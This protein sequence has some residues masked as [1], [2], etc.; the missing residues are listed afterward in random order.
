MVASPDQIVCVMIKT[1]PSV[2]HTRKNA[3]YNDV[4]NV[5]IH[6][7]KSWESLILWQ[8]TCTYTAVAMMHTAILH[9]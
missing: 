9:A 5:N 3:Y 7:S 2:V 8:C 4:K 1:K 6:A